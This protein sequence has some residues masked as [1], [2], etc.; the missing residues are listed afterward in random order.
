MLHRL[1]V[2]NPVRTSCD[3]QRTPVYTP[4]PRPSSSGLGRRPFTAETRVRFPLGVPASVFRTLLFGNNNHLLP[5]NQLACQAVAKHHVQH[6]GSKPLGTI[7]SATYARPSQPSRRIPVFA[8]QSQPCSR[9]G[10][11]GRF[12]FRRVRQQVDCTGLAQRSVGRVVRRGSIGLDRQ[13]RH[14]YLAA[15]LSPRAP[16]CTAMTRSASRP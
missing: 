5:L 9:F 15:T 11:L 14:C 1:C 4:S 16:P 8:P 2:K 10:W 12:S 13:R 3:P 7:T 6:G